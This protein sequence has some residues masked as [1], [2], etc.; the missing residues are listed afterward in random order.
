MAGRLHGIPPREYLVGVLRRIDNYST[1][2]RQML[3]RSRPP[4]ED[5]Q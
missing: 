4:H 2:Q 5:V 3:V 1:I